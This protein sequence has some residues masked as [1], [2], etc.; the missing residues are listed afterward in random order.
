MNK[1]KCCWCEK[2]LQGVINGDIS[3]VRISCN[4]KEC[5]EKQGE[6]NK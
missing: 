4:N 2:R 3:A 1:V 6:W 5:L